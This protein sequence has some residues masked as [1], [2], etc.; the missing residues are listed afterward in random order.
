MHLQCTP[1]SISD[2]I[3]LSFDFSNWYCSKYLEQELPFNNFD[4]DLEF[5][6]TIFNLNTGTHVN[7]SFLKNSDQL[8]IT[9]LFNLGKMEI[10][11][12]KNFYRE[13][14]NITNLYYIEFDFNNVINTQSIR[15]DFSIIHIN[16]RS[17]SKNIDSLST[18]LNTLDHSF[19]VIAITETWVMSTITS[20]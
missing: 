7:A 18:Y 20:F 3:Y 2:Y 6:N 8:K 16:A 10:E 1:L 14:R 5:K 17:L 9:N 11:P 13:R 19:S 4:D 12:D 15:S